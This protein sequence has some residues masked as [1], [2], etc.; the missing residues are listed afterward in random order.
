M[1]VDSLRT[2]A[3]RDMRRLLDAHQEVA[4]ATV[5]AYDAT[6]HTVNVSLAPLGDG[7]SIPVLPPFGLLAPLETGSTV[8]VLLVVGQPVY[9]LPLPS[10]DAPIPSVLHV[11]TDT[12]MAG[13]LT[14]GGPFTAPIVTQLPPATSNFANSIVIVA[15]ASGSPP[16]KSQP[17][18]CQDNGDSTVTWRALT[19][20]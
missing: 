9:A 12:F 18:F 11:P 16:T 1:A 20:T 3:Q 4:L 8:V 5:Q 19:L 14:I 10:P 13:A 17:Y 2:Q 7:V 15:A 6:T